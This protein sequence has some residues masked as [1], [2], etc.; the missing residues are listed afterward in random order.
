MHAIADDDERTTCW[1]DLDKKLMEEVVPWVPWLWRNYAN[2]I[3]D[4]VTKWDVR[5]V[6][7]HA[8]VAHVAVDQSK[9]Q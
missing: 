2:I 6:H 7:R 8:G 9:Q 5:P 4:S 1:G 3:S